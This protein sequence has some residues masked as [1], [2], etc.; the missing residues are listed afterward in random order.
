MSKW[1]KDIAIALDGFSSDPLYIQIYRQVAR[2]IRQ[3]ALNTGDRLPSIR[4]L[5]NDLDVSHIT[6]ERAYLQLMAE[7]YIKSV[8][9]SGYVV[10]AMDTTYF[11]LPDVDNRAAVDAI[12]KE[13]SQKVA[14]GSGMVDLSGN[15]QASYP[16]LRYNFTYY[17]LTKGSFPAKRWRRLTEEALFY[18]DN[19]FITTYAYPADTT[20]LQ[21][22]LARYLS[23]IRGV[24]CSPA[25]IIVFPGTEAAL[26]GLVR[27]VEPQTPMACEEPGYPVFV[28]A[29]RRERCTVGSL[30]V[31]RRY[32]GYVEAMR[33]LRPRLVFTT[34][35]NQYPTGSI[36]PIEKR[37]ELLQLA[38][39]LDA[40]VIEDDSCHEFFYET[41]AVPSLHH[42]DQQNRVI[43]LGNL[44]KVLS[45]AL[46]IAY[47]VLPPSLLRRYYELYPTS[48]QRVSLLEQHVL[49]R[50]IDEGDL[51]RHTRTMLMV[52]KKRNRVLTKALRDTFGERMSVAG[53]NSGLHVYAT[54]R[55]EMSQEE[56]IHR[57][58][59]EGAAVFGTQHCY[60][61]SPAPENSLFIG[62]SAIEAKDI[63]A[64]V[65]ALR[66]AWFS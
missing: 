36:M 25:Q 12:L 8:P 3:G 5:A 50:F 33:A 55:N 30:P 59:L 4:S 49:A 20:P 21:K 26:E 46:R 34:P 57:A 1:K 17:E 19:G 13:R 53:E 29:A 14:S 6:V 16:E 61:T 24:Q 23:R 38:H 22:A 52:L 63:P 7:G 27:L 48:H 2:G 42:L 54:V 39:E 11:E 65:E 43:Y 58:R 66:R 62:F 32:E 56:L 10:E 31:R 15:G 35:S 64:G 45:P 37:V 60:F 40:Y 18:P 44:S 28:E 47:G 9:K 41:R 51:D